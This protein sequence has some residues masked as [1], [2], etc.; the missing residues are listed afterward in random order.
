MPLRSGNRPVFALT[1]AKND[2]Q[3]PKSVTSS[4]KNQYEF[5]LR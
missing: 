1:F 4:P 3:V 2:V 5:N